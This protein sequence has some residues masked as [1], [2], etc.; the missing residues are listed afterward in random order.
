MNAAPLA[1]SAARGGILALKSGSQ[2]AAA[3]GVDSTMTATSSAAIATLRFIQAITI[4]L[5]ISGAPLDCG[6]GR[7]R[8]PPSRASGLEIRTR[9]SIGSE[10]EDR[11]G[12]R[13]LDRRSDA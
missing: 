12:L 11:D 6:R 10:R 5:R 7:A 1:A 9:A 13:I 2:G 3:D 4:P 8:K